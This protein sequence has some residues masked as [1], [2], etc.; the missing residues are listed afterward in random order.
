MRARSVFFASIASAILVSGCYTQVKTDGWPSESRPL[1]RPVPR[2]TA[3]PPPVA[4]HAPPVDDGVLRGEFIGTVQFDFNAGNADE[5]TY[6]SD[7]S[8]R[9][10]DGMYR[11]ESNLIVER[12]RYKDKGN[13]IVFDPPLPLP[14]AER[15]Q[16]WVATGA[17]G[18]PRFAAEHSEGAWNLTSQDDTQ[19]RTCKIVLRRLF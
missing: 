6:S 16:R 10:Q 4:V 12:G 14:P 18:I 9:F 7:I 2:E 3:P 1:Q 5:R 13:E 8:F 15:P 11:C 19:N 17:S